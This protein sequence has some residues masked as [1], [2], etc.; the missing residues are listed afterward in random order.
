MRS[1]IRSLS[2]R[3]L[4]AHRASGVGS[5]FPKMAALG[6]L[7]Q[8]LIACSLPSS[9]S[10]SNQNTA[11]VDNSPVAGL[12][13]TNTYFT[14]TKRV[15]M[16]PAEPK[17]QRGKPKLFSV[18]PAIPKGISFDSVTGTFTGTSASKVALTHYI[19]TASNTFG[20]SRYDFDLEV[21]TTDPGKSTVATSK[22]S[23]VADG[24]DT[25]TVTITALDRNGIA[26]TNELVKLSSN[27]FTDT[28]TPATVKT[29]DQGIAK[30][31]VSSTVSGAPTFFASDEEDQVVILQTAN[32]NFTPGPIDKLLWVSPPSNSVAGQAITL[33][34]RALDANNNTTTLV[35]GSAS[36]TQ[37]GPVSLN[38]PSPVVLTSGE[39]SFAAFS[40][41]VSGSYT[42]QATTG[43]VSSTNLAISISPSTPVKLTYNDQP[44][45]MGTAGTLLSQNPSVQVRDQY[46]NPVTSSAVSVSLAPYAD[47]NCQTL[48]TPLNGIPTFDV[49]RNPVSTSSGVASFSALKIYKTSI[50]SLGASGTD[51]LG[52]RLT[53]ACSAPITIIPGAASSTNSKITGTSLIL[54]DGIK[55]STITVSLLDDYQN[56]VPGKT[57]VFTATDTGTTNTYGNCSA[58][59]S[60]GNSNCTL[61]SQR[62][63][64][65]TLYLTT[66]TVTGAQVEFIAGAAKRFEMTPNWIKNGVGNELIL[67]ARALDS[68]GNLATS[69]SGSVNLTATTDPQ[70]QIPVNLKMSAGLITVPAIFLKT[71]GSLTLTLSDA[72]DASILGTSALTLTPC[73]SLNLSSRPQATS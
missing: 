12:T 72:S 21:L 65:K 61:S 50:V 22:T 64:K 8:T 32:L 49:A 2:N 20:F 46:D 52:N 4:G 69:Y 29:D 68:V 17:L 45:S 73:P 63:E 51:A 48:V 10:A 37:T 42:F 23:V 14:M 19:V 57:P 39:A 16:V 71:A 31:T 54:A 36:L 26:I 67:S 7:T 62:A 24:R 38:L 1:F 18:S 47:S 40:P 9:P 53:S 44:S 6:F 13:Y 27:R 34:I 33:S 55:T 3:F 58:T 5:L 28:I 11:P 25:T 15:P 66:P 70:A 60:T 30:F 43:N 59:D 56:A 35:P 41:T